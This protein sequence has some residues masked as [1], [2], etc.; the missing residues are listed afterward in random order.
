MSQTNNI[1][2]TDASFTFF[3]FHSVPASTTH[4]AKDFLV[5]AVTTVAGPGIELPDLLDELKWNKTFK[6]PNVKR[7]LRSLAAEA[8]QEFAAG[9]TEEGGF[10]VE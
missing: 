6:D 9:E 7:G 8:L 2:N 10:S 1:Y 5:D 3:S 4:Q